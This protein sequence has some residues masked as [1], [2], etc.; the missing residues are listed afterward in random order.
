MSRSG[1]ARA[2]ASSRWYTRVVPLSVDKADPIA[3]QID[4]IHR[5]VAARIRRDPD[6]VCQAKALLCR[7]IERE[8]PPTHPALEEWRAVFDFLLPDEI[9]N[10]LE[11]TTPRARRMRVSSPFMTLGKQES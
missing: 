6:V 7:W 4:E 3:R 9:A 10:F 5:R 8:G 11:S 1:S 2:T